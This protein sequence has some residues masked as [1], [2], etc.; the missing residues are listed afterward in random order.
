MRLTRHRGRPKAL[1]LPA[2]AIALVAMATAGFLWDSGGLVLVARINDYVALLGWLILIALT[3][4]V[5]LGVTRPVLRLVLCALLLGPGIPIMLFVTLLASIGTTEETKN[6]AAPG[7]SDRRLVVVE[8]SSFADP[9][10]SVYVHEGTWPLER[11]R[12]VGFFDG[13]FVALSEAVWTAPDRIRMTTG[14]GEVHEVTIAPGG[15]PDRAAIP[16]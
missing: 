9:L 11:R 7:R 10:W 2:T 13:D 3:G 1:A 14:E 4:A 16:R 12:L 8:G 5:L 6:E 15:R